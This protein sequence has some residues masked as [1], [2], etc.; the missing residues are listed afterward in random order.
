MQCRDYFG[1]FKLSLCHP[2]IL[3]V[4][5]HSVNSFFFLHKLLHKLALSLLR[6]DK[7]F[8]AGIKTKR[9]KAALDPDYLL[10]VL[11]P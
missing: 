10:R 6:H 1:E 9:L 5:Q 4:Y 7:S 3:G 11:S 8:K 2:P